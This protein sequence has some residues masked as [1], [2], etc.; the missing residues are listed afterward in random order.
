MRILSV[1]QSCRFV[2]ARS[3]LIL[4]FNLLVVLATLPIARAGG[5][6]F[7][8][9]SKENSTP[10][11]LSTGQDVISLASVNSAGT[12]SGNGE[13]RLTALSANGRF[14]VF[15]SSATNLVTGGLIDTNNAPDVFVYDRL[16]SFTDCVS[17]RGGSNFTANAASGQVGTNGTLGISAD[18]RFIVY[19]SLASDIVPLDTNG[20]ADVFIFDRSNGATFLVSSKH[21]DFTAGANGPSTRPAISA[22]GHVVVYVSSATDLTAT[23]DTN[24]KVDVYAR[25]LNNLVTKLISECCRQ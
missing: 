23:G 20:V 8:T 21:N 9:A 14:I 17:R 24:G 13:S 25:N 18:G 2:S 4:L 7:A 12:D 16:N 6:N 5:Q 11:I 10:D 15:T 22:D 3:V 19:A 1:V